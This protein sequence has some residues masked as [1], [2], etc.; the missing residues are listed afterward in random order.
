MGAIGKVTALITRKGA[1]G[2]EVWVFVHPRAGMHLPAGTLEPGESVRAAALR[3]AFEETGPSEVRFESEVAIVP[4]APPHTAAISRPVVVAGRLVRAGYLAHVV[5]RGVRH[6][7]IEVD[8]V[9]G[10]VPL[11]A[12]SF[13]ADATWS[14]SCATAPQQTNG[15][16]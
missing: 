12:L 2:Q 4:A 11:D 7:R 14:T 6:A 16:S 13:D 15:S 8:G 5:E 9:E 3:E 10:F 1:D